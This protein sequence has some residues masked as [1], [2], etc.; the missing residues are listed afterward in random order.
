MVL[1]TTWTPNSKSF[2]LYIQFYSALTSSVIRKQYR[3]RAKSNDRQIFITAQMVIFRRRFI[4]CSRLGCPNLFLGL[5]RRQ[6]E[7]KQKLFHFL[8]LRL[9]L[10]KWPTRNNRKTL[11]LQRSSLKKDVFVATAVE[12]SYKFPINITCHSHKYKKCNLLP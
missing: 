6:S 7:S 5:R 2:I 10:A 12:A 3:M 8:P 9:F 1:T 4:C 11:N